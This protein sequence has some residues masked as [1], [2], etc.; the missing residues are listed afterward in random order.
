MAATNQ[1]RKWRDRI[2][3][4]TQKVEDAPPEVGWIY[5]ISKPT[6]NDILSP[7]STS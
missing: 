3:H 2:F 4:H 6:P 1:G 7:G 5:A